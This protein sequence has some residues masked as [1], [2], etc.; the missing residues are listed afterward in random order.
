MKK[1]LII[2]AHPDD[3]ILGC[4]GLIKKNIQKKNKIRILFLAEGVTSRY[5]KNELNNSIVIKKSEMRNKNAIL[6]LNSLGVKKS[7]IF[8]STNKCCRLDD[9]NQ[10]EIVK[11]IEK[12]IEEFKP[13][14]IF[15][16][17]HSDANI[18]HRIVHQATITASRPVY[19]FKINLIASYEVLSS[20][21]WNFKES[22]N[23]NY[24]E[25]I[26]DIPNSSQTLAEI[27]NEKF[28]IDDLVKVD[29]LVHQ[30]KSL[31][32]LILEMEDEVLANAGVDSFEEIFKLIFGVKFKMC[33]VI[34]TSKDYS[35]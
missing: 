21:E 1:I 35:W 19:K 6:A 33:L 12:H 5:P 11:V 29:K 22:F 10:L 8:L 28:T 15:T 30:K 20:T 2:S 27:K 23:P 4:G 17:W 13:N 34:L 9:F 16:H 26:T 14:Q 31:K 24:F 25:D 18:D 3:E 7:E 32:N